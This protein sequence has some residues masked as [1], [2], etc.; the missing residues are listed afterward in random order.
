MSNNKEE[1]DLMQDDKEDK[2]KKKDEMHFK[3]VY[4]DK[5][6]SFWGK[7][8]KG[9]FLQLTEPIDRNILSDYSKAEA[10]MKEHYDEL[11]EKLVAVRH[12]PEFRVKDRKSG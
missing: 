6:Y 7:V 10:Y 8:G 11:K 3:A 5:G 2:K 4:T 9:R 1:K 12:M